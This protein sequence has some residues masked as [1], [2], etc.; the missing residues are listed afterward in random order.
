[1]EIAAVGV[2]I[3]ILNQ[4]L[5]ITVSPLV[6]ITTS[7]V[8]EEYAIGRLAKQ[9]QKNKEIEKVK[10]EDVIPDSLEK[11]CS[12][13]NSGNIEAKADNA[14]LSDST[15]S[16]VTTVTESPNVEYSV[17]N[18]SQITS[19]EKKIDLKT[20]AV[21]KQ[22]ITPEKRYIPSASTS[23]IMGLVVGIVQ[24]IFLISLAK[25]LL[26][27]MGVKSV[28]NSLVSRH[29]RYFIF[30]LSVQRFCIH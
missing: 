18:K 29:V 19:K 21:V 25:P 2:S 15:S 8:A 3:A 12:A 20:N 23:L 22:V 16:C 7:F 13:T 17:M 6:S 4:A 10:A 1:M 14:T 24:T 9:V 30:F 11:G 28:S 5:R 26:R 27:I